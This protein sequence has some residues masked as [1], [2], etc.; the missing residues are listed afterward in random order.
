VALTALKKAEDGEGLVARLYE[1][2]GRPAEARVTLRFAELT[3][4]G[5]LGPFEIKTLRFDLEARRAAE[6]DLLERPL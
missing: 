6:T 4:E 3:W 2:A 5:R 1:T